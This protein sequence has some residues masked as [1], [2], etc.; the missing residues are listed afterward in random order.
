M[1][2]I[3]L[4]ATAALLC[5]T[6][7]LAVVA[8]G[9]TSST[10]LGRPGRAAAGYRGA[11]AVGPY[12][13]SATGMRRGATVVGPAGGSAG[14]RAGGGTVTTPRGGS[15]EYSGAAVGRTGPA[16]GAAG[17]Y[18]GGVQV[19]TPGGRTATRV[20]TGGGVVG[21]GGTAVGGRTTVGAASGPRGTAVG[22]GHTG[23]A[24]GPGG[25]VAGGYRGGVAVGPYG[26]VAA[27]AAR[28][29]AVVTRG[30]AVAA[31]PGTYFVS[32][33]ALRTQGTYVR[34]GFRY[35]N[36]FNPAWYNRYPGAWR[37]ARWTAAAVWIPATWVALSRFCSYPAAPVY[38]DYGTTVV[39]Q[40]TTVYVNGEPAATAEQ[41][42]QQAMQLSDAG[43]T[44]QPPPTEEWQSLGVFALVRGEEQTSDKIFQ[45]AVNNAGLIRGNYYDALADN[46]LPV[47][48]SVDPKTQR[49]AWSIGE[50]KDV[51]FEAGVA[52]LTRDETPILVHYGTAD[53]QQLALV[54]IEPPNVPGR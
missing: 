50:K 10:A 34:T 37:P 2:P 16:G 28:G 33:A 51:I 21:P 46:N 53:T 44:A 20:G 49:A 22:V 35:Y 45:L 40:G 43:R 17:H 14:Y 4:R 38:Y 42:A 3:N 8:F 32:G 6:L 25:V 47:Y 41:Y 52:N 5:S 36:T 29:G 30:G 7:V 18:V 1:R 23:G 24:V 13:G 12:G 19:T 9:L 31:R 26:G 39:Y 11:A 15:I 54:R 48:G 27:G